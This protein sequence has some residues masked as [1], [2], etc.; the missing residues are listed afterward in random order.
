MSRFTAIEMPIRT[1]HSYLRVY[2]E[3]LTR[4][5]DVAVSVVWDALYWL[6]RGET[7]LNP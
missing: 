4:G 1:Y 6:I 2:L 3:V 7:D 5:C